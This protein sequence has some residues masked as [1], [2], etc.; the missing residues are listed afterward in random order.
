MWV[1]QHKF[2]V[3]TKTSQ[4]RPFTELKI[5]QLHYYPFSNPFC[6]IRLELKKVMKVKSILYLY[7]FQILCFDSTIGLKKLNQHECNYQF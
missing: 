3:S 1:E 4:I 5:K 7:I 6:L 2:F